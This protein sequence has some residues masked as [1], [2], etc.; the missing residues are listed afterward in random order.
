VARWE[1]CGAFVDAL[2]SALGSGHPPAVA[3]TVVI[4]P[5]VSSTVPIGAAVGAAAVAEQI[6]TEATEPELATMATAYPSPPLGSPPPKPRRRR[7]LVLIALGLIL[8]LAAGGAVAWSILNQPA[9]VSISPDTAVAGSSVVVTA[10]HVPPN[11]VGEIQLWSVERIVPFRADGNGNVSITLDIPRYLAPGDHLVKVCWGGTCHADHVLHVM[12]PL[13]TP[14]PSPSPTRSPTPSASPTPAPLV[15]VLTSSV[16]P[17][18]NESVG[19]RY[20]PGTSAAIYFVQG[21]S[22][23]GL[24]TTP[25]SSGRFVT[26]V[27]IPSTARPGAAAIRACYVGGCAYATINVV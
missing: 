1:S 26:T 25:V 14:S 23:V 10:S 5:Q 7:S 18:D 22:V 9:T 24:G 20:F 13:A 27:R 3:A 21:T 15:E 17:G 12:A 6:A 8:L 11:Q 4:A 2:T 16:K 19:G